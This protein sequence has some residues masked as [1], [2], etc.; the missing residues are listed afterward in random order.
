MKKCAALEDVLARIAAITGAT[1][2]SAL[3]KELG[4]AKQT[5][6]TWK[7]RG[8]IPYERTIQ[9]AD[10]REISLDYLLLGKGKGDF[11]GGEIDPM[12]LEGIGLA[13]EVY[14]RLL[15]HRIRA[16]AA[17]DMALV[18]NRVIKQLRPGQNWGELVKDEVAY[19]VE[20]KKQQLEQ[21]SS[22]HGTS[23]PVHLHEEEQRHIKKIGAT[24]EEI[25]GVPAANPIGGDN[26]K[27]KQHIEGEN[28]QIAGRDLVNKGGR[29]RKK[30]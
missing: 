2:D 4:V 28:H 18:Y 16:G 25:Y 7:S 5:L 6:S 19:L 15:L 24:V 10:E 11:S 13:F 27:V 14:D 1:S 22:G 17:Y 9:F 8:T 29:G 30:K 3:A 20:I 12:L 23:E 21:E 26:V